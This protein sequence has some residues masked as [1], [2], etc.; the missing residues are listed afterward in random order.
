MNDRPALVRPVTGQQLPVRAFIESPVHRQ[1]LCGAVIVKQAAGPRYE[2]IKAGNMG[3]LRREAWR[4]PPDFRSVCRE[5]Y[6]PKIAEGYVLNEV[7]R[8]SSDEFLSG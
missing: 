4:E 1:C 2:R 7:W 3:D 8:M 5:P 6:E